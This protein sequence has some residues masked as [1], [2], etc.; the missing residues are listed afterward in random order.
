MRIKIRDY[1]DNKSGAEWIPVTYLP[2][3]EAWGIG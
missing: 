1:L 3:K 2:N